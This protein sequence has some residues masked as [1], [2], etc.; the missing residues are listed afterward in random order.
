[1]DAS[2]SNPCCCC[3]KNTNE[4]RGRLGTDADITLNQSTG[5]T[6]F[7]ASYE[8]PTLDDQSTT[9]DPKEASQMWPVLFGACCMA[10]G[11]LATQ[12]MIT[13]DAKDE[14]LSSY[15]KDATRE[16]QE[17]VKNGSDLGTPVYV[18][19]ICGACFGDVDVEELRAL[20]LRANE[21]NL[22]AR[23]YATFSGTK[24]FAET[25]ATHVAKQN[26]CTSWCGEEDV[27][28]LKPLSRGRI[29]LPIE[30]QE[31]THNEQGVANSMGNAVYGE[32]SLAENLRSDTIGS[33]STDHRSS[34]ASTQTQRLGGESRHEYG[35]T[36]DFSA[37]FT[38]YSTS[39][40]SSHHESSPGSS[41]FPFMS[42]VDAGR[43]SASSSYDSTT[44]MDSLTVV[45]KLETVATASQTVD[46]TLTRTSRLSLADADDC[47]DSAAVISVAESWPLKILG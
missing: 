17:I 24:S 45:S 8:E 38:S 21:L 28:K 39:Y 26:I 1:M 19:S 10:S 42:E 6:D 41:C 7:P 16:G 18:A 31:R 47:S 3:G 27:D 15:V 4:A 44:T 25:V 37:G 23:R 9:R 40:A 11:T 2:R 35:D 13:S 14:S 12:N 5:Q 29:L 20:K 33:D 22:R 30:N 43:K 46:E 32:K 36:S 34:T